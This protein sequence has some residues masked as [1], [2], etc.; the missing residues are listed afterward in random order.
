MAPL[1]AEPLAFMVRLKMIRPVPG[2]EPLHKTFEVVIPAPSASEARTAGA[3]FGNAIQRASQ[4][5]WHW[6]APLANSCITVEPYDEKDYDAWQDD[7]LQ[8]PWRRLSEL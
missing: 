7:I 6:A 8:Q 1:Q 3:E 5:K 2:E 4:G